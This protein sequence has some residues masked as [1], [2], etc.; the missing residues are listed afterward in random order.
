[1]RQPAAMTS[2]ALLLEYAQAGLLQFGRFQVGEEFWPLAF[3]FTLLPSF[4]RLLYATA[5]RLLPHLTPLSER[6]RLLTMPNTIALGGVVAT[7]T[8]IP[9]LY[10][11]GEVKSYTAAFAIEGAADVGHPTTLLTDALL[12][13]QIEAQISARAAQV[14]LPVR[15]VVAVLEAGHGGETYLHDKMAGVQVTS[16]WSLSEALT[17]L[18]EAGYL[19]SGMAEAVRR[20]QAGRA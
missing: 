15:R 13:G 5:Q 9:M 8:D 4:P 17:W 3:H 11:H 10:P 20:W 16:L 19:T 6:D 18:V 1:M 12:N 14:G 7:L 2:Q